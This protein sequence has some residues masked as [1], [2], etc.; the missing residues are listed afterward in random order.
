MKS[1]KHLKAPVV[2]RR[3]LNRVLGGIST[4]AIA[5]FSVGL[6]HTQ[7][8]PFE[9]IQQFGDTSD[10]AIRG[11]AL[12]AEGNCFVTGTYRGL[13]TFGFIQQPSLGELDSFVSKYSPEGDLLWT[14]FTG[15]PDRNEVAGIALD[16]RGNAFI[17]GSFS[18]TNILGTNIQIASRVMDAFVASYDSEGELKWAKQYGGGGFEFLQSLSI[19]PAGNLFVAGT[20]NSKTTSFGGIVLSNTYQGGIFAST[21]FDIFLA[22]LDPR[23]EVLWARSVGGLP[24]ENQVEL[25]PEIW[26]DHSGSAYLSGF[27][28]S[29]ILRVGSLSLSNSMGYFLAKYDSE[30]NAVWARTQ[31]T[32]FS[33]PAI[34]RLGN[35][36]VQSAFVNAA[37]LDGL[38]ISNRFNPRGNG[39]YIAKYSPEWNLIW[40]VAGGSTENDIP[41]AIT[42]D[43]FENCYATGGYSGSWKFGS[44]TLPDMSAYSALYVLKLDSLGR[45]QWA[46]GAGNLSYSTIGYGIGVDADGDCRLAGSFDG[47]LS[48][49]QTNLVADAGGT[50]FVLKGPRPPPKIV[51]QPRSQTVRVGATVTFSVLA[52]GEAPLAYQ[53]LFD[54][55]ALPSA[56]N[57]TLIL[58]NTTHAQ[59]GFYTCIVS[60]SA[61]AVMS[62]SAQ[63]MFDF[64]TIKM[65]AG[66]TIDGE[67]GQQFQVQFASALGNPIHWQ[68]LAIVTLTNVPY[69]FV[70]PGSPDATKRLYRA[71]P[72][73]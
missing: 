2:I 32:R 38:V 10:A 66:L 51:T 43:Q 28:E 20:F 41:R 7:T 68:A 31:A 70:D 62:T 67:V 3:F 26:V 4:G 23:G 1:S 9:W 45:A 40:A 30:G 48:L 57:A 52:V 54:G 22:K 71:I 73:P 58:P 55:A 15:G 29:P 27:S 44:L 46:Y 42:V 13:G 35:F 5:I 69:L 56:T 59:A 72:W 61:A 11:T 36:Y 24:G 33:R 16:A 60:N 18:F 53:W 8:V 14:R 65:Y 12:D 63:L 19:D 50:L 17:A 21:T 49:G 25:Y 47:T 39:T 6:G 64:L 34:D 37:I